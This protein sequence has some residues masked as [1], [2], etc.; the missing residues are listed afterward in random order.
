MESIMGNEEGKREQ[1]N[2]ARATAEI[3]AFVVTRCL[4][5]LPLLPVKKNHLTI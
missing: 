3:V 4:L 2:K 1:G 5:P